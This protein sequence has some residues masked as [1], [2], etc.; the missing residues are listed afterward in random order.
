MTTYNYYRVGPIKGRAGSV[1]HVAF[2]RSSDGGGRL[3]FADG[4]KL[5]L[6]ECRLT[7]PELVK[8]YNWLSK[9]IKT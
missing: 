8:F 2:E 7:E 6:K 9:Q 5:V 4:Y 1:S 3:I